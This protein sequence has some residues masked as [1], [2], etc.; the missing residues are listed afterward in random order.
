[1][2]ISSQALFMEVCTLEMHR[3]PHLIFGHCRIL[4]VMLSKSI[5]TSHPCGRQENATSVAFLGRGR[6]GGFGIRD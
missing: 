4:Q 6:F 2:G 5:A 1:M 3:Q